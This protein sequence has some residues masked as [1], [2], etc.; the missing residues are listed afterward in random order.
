MYAVTQTRKN[1]IDSH[2]PFHI[3]HSTCYY[4]TYSLLL[5]H[6]QPSSLPSTATIPINAL[7]GSTRFTTLTHKFT[8]SRSRARH[9][10]H[11][12]VCLQTIHCT[13]RSVPDLD[14][15]PVA[16][17]IYHLDLVRY[18]NCYVIKPVSLEERTRMSLLRV[19]DDALA[20]I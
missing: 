17:I 6:L 12:T 4:Y 20:W 7:L 13:V 16:I 9:R 5:T 2:D 15:G 10:P 11:R 8:R 3:I 14:S 1:V 19:I 18:C